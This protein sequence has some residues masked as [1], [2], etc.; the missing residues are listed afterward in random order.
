MLCFVLLL[1]VI[2]VAFLLWWEL[3]DPLYRKLKIVSSQPQYKCFQV[4]V[5]RLESA[6]QAEVKNRC[7]QVAVISTEEPIDITATCLYL[8]T[9][10]EQVSLY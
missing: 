8:S 3:L 5:P 4:S 2:D 1:V 7:G 9:S 6:L 10:H